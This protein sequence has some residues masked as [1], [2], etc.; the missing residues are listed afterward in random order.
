ML[1]K[2]RV[3][4]RRKSRTCLQ[5]TGPRLGSSADVDPVYYTNIA[6]SFKSSLW[7]YEFAASVDPA[8]IAD[9]LHCE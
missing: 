8:L 4:V 6:K 7:S 5:E 1:G 3:K 9:V 2:N